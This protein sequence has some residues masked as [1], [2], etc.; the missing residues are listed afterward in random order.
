MSSVDPSFVERYQILLE[1]DPQSR[2]FAALAEAYRKMG[3][4]DEA[5]SLCK[6]GLKFHPEFASGHVA[7]AKIHMDRQNYEQALVELQKS[8]IHAPENLLAHGLKGEVLLRMRRPKEALKAYKMILLLNP[9]DD[10]AAMAIRQLESL[11]ADE[12]EEDLFT[13][14]PLTSQITSPNNRLAPNRE[15]QRSVLKAKDLERLMSLSDAFAVRN[16]FDKAREVLLKIK[17]AWGATPDVERRLKRL[18][19][20][21]S[22]RSAHSNEKRNIPFHDSKI[23]LLHRL[24]NQIENRKFHS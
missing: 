16:Q 14:E 23:L 12:Y 9:S 4:L 21:N 3:M 7:L 11:T 5:E 6:K 15:N 2:G 1:R 8:I 13:L 18:G 24:L 17:N 10:R 19:P 20:D 22:L